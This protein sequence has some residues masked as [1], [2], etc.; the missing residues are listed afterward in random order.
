MLK[1]D[2][3]QVTIIKILFFLGYAAGAAWLTYF[4]VYL[5]DGAGLS[6]FEIGIIASLQQFNNIFVLPVWGILADR[7][8]RKKML[9]FSIGA[10]IL[11]L[12]LFIFLKGAAALTLF[13]ILVTFAYN[14]IASLIDTIALDYEAQSR[15]KASYGEFRLWAS[16]GWG[17]SSMLTGIFIS[18]DNLYLIFPIASGMFLITWILLVTIYKPLIVKDNLSNLRR[19]VIWDLLKSERV[20]LAFFLLVFFYSIFSAPIYLMINVY[21][22]DIGASNNII[23]LAFLI[24]GLCEL[25]FFF[26]GKRIVDRFGAK[27][28]FLFTMIATAIRMFLYGINHSPQVALAIGTIQGISIG[29][30]FVSV[31]S[32]VHRIIPPNL[33]STGQSLFYTFYAVGVAF[34]NIATGVLFDYFS[35]NTTMLLNAFGIIVLVLLVLLT[36]KSFTKFL[37]P[38]PPV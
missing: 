15:G 12:P 14:P 8:G 2:E 27:N 30:F 24:Q 26:Y 17:A 28:V 11:L 6:G 29:L 36:R 16:L 7:Y 38:K 1:A 20:L 13:V 5:K 4:Y 35:M 3:H 34:G 21:Y 31:V 18:S 32:I 25:P 22:L 19:G 9:I 10:S 23:G 37:V 33:R